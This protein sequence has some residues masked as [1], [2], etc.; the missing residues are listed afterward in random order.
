MCATQH[1]WQGLNFVSFHVS[2]SLSVHLSP[3]WSEILP[4]ETRGIGGMS[5]LVLKENQLPS[6][7]F[8]INKTWSV[9][10]TQCSKQRGTQRSVA[11]S[12]MV[13]NIWPRPQ[14]PQALSSSCTPYAVGWHTLKASRQ[15]KCSWS[16]LQMRKL[17]VGEIGSSLLSLSPSLG[18]GTL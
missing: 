2:S 12:Q 7:S 14:V 11:L 3:F 4:R 1:A 5:V 18:E 9:I 6:I 10:G 17:R 8:V 13:A 16:I 15:G